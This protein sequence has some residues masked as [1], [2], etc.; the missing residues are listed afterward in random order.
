MTLLAPLL[1]LYAVDP[2][3]DYIEKYA[4]MAVAER[5]ANGIPASITLAQGLLESA[6]G[7]S[8]LARE[9]N[10]HF[11]IKCHAGWTGDTILRNDDAANECFRV[12]PSAQQSFTDHSR[13]L[14][15]R[16]YASLFEIPIEDYSS[17]AHGLRS[18]GYAT[19]P[20][21]ATRLIAIIE[22][23]S[24]NLYDTDSERPDL[25]AEHIANTLKATHPV[26]RSRGLLYVIAN[27]GDTYA[28]IAREMNIKAERL[29]VLN[30]AVADGPIKA[31]EEVYLMEKHDEAPKGM[32]KITIGDDESFHSI[33][34]R[35]GMRLESL[36]QL[37]PDAP[38]TPG[39]RLR[40]R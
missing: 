27:P 23:Y 12:Y 20:N 1:P 21:Y 32:K 8:K 28:S 13:F 7:K 3:K 2:Y 11:G 10:N 24:L 31:W 29:M 25:M 4:E 15:T 14:K 18:C 16:R 35:L 22:R 9:G 38:D 34:Q 36:R 33:A 19:D 37:N 6:A 17:W 30:D 40:L 26:R 39:T 5:K